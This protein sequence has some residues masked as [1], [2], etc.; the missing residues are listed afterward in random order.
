VLPSLLEN[1]L[2]SPELLGSEV[3]VLRGDSMFPCPYTTQPPF[4]P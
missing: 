1:A 4:L 2:Q 3:W